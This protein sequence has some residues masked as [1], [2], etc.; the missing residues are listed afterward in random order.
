M[1][2]IARYGA[3][4]LLGVFSFNNDEETLYHGTQVIVRTSRGQEQATVLCA[5]TPKVLEHLP[6]EMERERILRVM[7]EDDRKE[8]K[9]IRDGEKDEFVRCQQIIERMKLN[10]VL[11]RIEHI[12]GGERII[13]YYV[14]DG[15]VDFRELVKVLAA[16]F[17]TRIEMK[18]IGVR[19]ET[20]LLA[21]IGDCGR[22][23]CCNSYLV[24]MPPVSMKM[25]KLQ[26][27]TLDPTK[28]SGRCGRL[29]CCLR[30]EY[31]TYNDL[32]S[33]LPPVGRFVIT[34]EGKG[35]VISQELFARRILVELEEGTQQMFS[36]EDVRPV[37]NHDDRR[38]TLHEGNGNRKND[39]RRDEPNDG[40]GQDDVK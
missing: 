3:M 19:D 26:K 34:P 22:E 29:K 9:R 2:Y 28:V 39:D 37:R 7:T 8:A 18:Q 30:Y 17:Q 23:V 38:A 20:K 16:E 27:A 13:I 33:I 5:E 24:V 12:F 14:A 36:V 40:T 15:R 1:N 31:D 11:V 4:R 6:R 32:Q 25:A 10:M 21:D 35:K